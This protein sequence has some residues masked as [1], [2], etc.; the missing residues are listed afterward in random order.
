MSTE[1]KNGVYPASGDENADYIEMTYK[2]LYEKQR[3]GTEMV[4]T[5]GKRIRR[6]NF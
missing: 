2:E 6:R 3:P 1:K 5:T 4:G